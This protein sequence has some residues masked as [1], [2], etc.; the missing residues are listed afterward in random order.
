M[1]NL[2]HLKVIQN[3][4]IMFNLRI[5]AQAAQAFG[6]HRTLGAKQHFARILSSKFTNFP[7]G[8]NYSIVEP[9]LRA[10]IQ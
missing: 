6:G 1:E 2:R 8:L 5:A 7:G 4:Y 3:K 9:L 10:T